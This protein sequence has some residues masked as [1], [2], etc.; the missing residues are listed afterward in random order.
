MYIGLIAY[1]CLME[2]FATSRKGQSSLL[3]ITPRPNLLRKFRQ[4]CQERDISPTELIN[5]ILR[6]RYKI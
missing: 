5:Q 6:E 1:I 2:K 4:E 3:R